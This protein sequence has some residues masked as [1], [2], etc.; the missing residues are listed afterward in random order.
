[1]FRITIQW[2]DG[3]SHEN[4]FLQT[5]GMD[6]SNTIT[7]S[8]DSEKISVIIGKRPPGINQYETIN[9]FC[10]YNKLK[11]FLKDLSYN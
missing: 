5:L 3:E 7:N 1:M 9:I 2:K 11:Q 4:I 10:N 8:N 6:F